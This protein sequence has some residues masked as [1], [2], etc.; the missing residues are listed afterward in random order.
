MVSDMW[1]QLGVDSD[2]FTIPPVR[3]TDREY[4]QSFPGG[5]IVG[6][7]SRD[8][9][10]TRL[11]CAEMPTPNNAYA[12]NN[13]G[14]WCNQ[15]YDRLVNVYRTDLTEAGRGRT[16]AQIQNLLVEELP[17]LLLNVNVAVVFART[18]VTAYADDFAGGSEAGRIYGTYSR[19]AHEWDI[20]Q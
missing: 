1:K 14:H 19:N 6:R 15:D 3:T 12:G 2:I 13:R 11:E 16:I 8:S 18:G 7:G 4:L 5:E 10:L 9:V 17:L 20:V